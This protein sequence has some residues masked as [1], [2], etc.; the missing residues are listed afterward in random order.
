M[1]SEKPESSLLNDLKLF[2]AHYR[3]RDPR[4][5]QVRGLVPGE[6][7]EGY[8]TLLGNAIERAWTHRGTRPLPP[9]YEGP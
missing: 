3:G 8:A 9:G 1:S 6:P 2:L 7:P 5:V 4:Q